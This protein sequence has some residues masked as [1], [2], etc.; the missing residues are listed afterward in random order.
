MAQQKKKD[1]RPHRATGKPRGRPRK[2]GTPAQPKSAEQKEQEALVKAE[3]KEIAAKEF[4]ENE[5]TT[6]QRMLRYALDG[7]GEKP[8]D[9]NDF[10]AVKSRVQTYFN[11]CIRYD[12]KPT[13]IGVCRRLGIT[14]Q[15]FWK[16]RTGAA[17]NSN[18]QKLAEDI[19]A[20]IEEMTVEL[21]YNNDINNIQAIV[22]LKNHFGYTDEQK[23]VVEPRQSFIDDTMTMADVLAIAEQPTPKIAEFTDI[24]ESAESAESEN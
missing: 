17:R 21:A 9:L 3:R 4:M 2:D 15:A 7:W 23:V 14:K 5:P 6:N 18:Y 20:I 11:D 8:V 22:Q 24:N 12:L 10:R 19:Y 16:W 13:L 1:T